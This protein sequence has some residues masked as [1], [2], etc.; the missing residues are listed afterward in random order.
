MSEG[1][2]Q[3][4]SLEDGASVEYPGFVLPLVSVGVIGERGFLPLADVILDGGL[5]V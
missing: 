2:F 1:A 5:V 4:M 3:R